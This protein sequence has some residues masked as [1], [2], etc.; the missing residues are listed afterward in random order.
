[1]D[2]KERE[3]RLNSFYIGLRAKKLAFMHGMINTPPTDE[4]CEPPPE[5]LPPI[6]C[7]KEDE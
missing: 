2:E 7:E 3:R 4:E 6:Y 5:L 1:M